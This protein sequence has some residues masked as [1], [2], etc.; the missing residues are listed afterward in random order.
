[1]ELQMGTDSLV[2]PLSTASHYEGSNLPMQLDSSTAI[3][4]IHNNC[5]YFCQ[6]KTM[7]KVDSLVRAVY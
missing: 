3:I 7:A 4:N 2:F 5:H 6:N 1:M